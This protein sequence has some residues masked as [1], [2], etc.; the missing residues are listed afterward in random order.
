MNATCNWHKRDGFQINVWKAL[1]KMIEMKKISVEKAFKDL[2]HIN[3]DNLDDMIIDATLKAEK[4][5][6][7]MNC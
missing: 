7:A 1:S 6:K 5:Q 2:L 4:L 3:I